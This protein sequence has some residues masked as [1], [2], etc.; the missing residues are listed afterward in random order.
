MK[1]SFFIFLRLK[2]PLDGI[3]LANTET[4]LGDVLLSF[5]LTLAE[6]FLDFLVLWLGSPWAILGL[7][8]WLNLCFPINL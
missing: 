7:L 3:N 1:G 8:P 6:R 5:D 2:S 4:F